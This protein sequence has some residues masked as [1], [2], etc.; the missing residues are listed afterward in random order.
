MR[1]AGYD[2]GTRKKN[3]F[4]PTPDFAIDSILERVAFEGEVWEPSCGD[5]AI[6][7]KL[8]EYGYDVK[9]T[10]L[11]DYGY[12][13]TGIDF[14]TQNEPCDNIMTNPPFSI[15]TEYA[16]NAVRLARRKVLILNKLT[17]L[18]GQG[19]AAKLF[20]QK[21]LSNVWVFSGRLQFNQYKNGGMICF[22]W[23]LFDKGYYGDTKLEWICTN[24]TGSNQ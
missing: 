8:I 19:R 21:N 12:G 23:F 1:L 24:V 10:D 17:F 15:S 4:Y 11:N 7:K 18:E 20:S 13:E 14:L 3:D 5:G 6:S 9:S 22:A 2:V 16:L